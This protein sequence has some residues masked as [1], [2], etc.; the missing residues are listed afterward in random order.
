MC[1][2]V[3]S[4]RS[5]YRGSRIVARSDHCVLAYSTLSMYQWV[6]NNSV[7]TGRY[8]SR[9]FV[10]LLLKHYVTLYLYIAF[11]LNWTYKLSIVLLIQIKTLHRQ[12]PTVTLVLKNIYSISLLWSKLKNATLVCV[13][14]IMNTVARSINILKLKYIMHLCYTLEFI[15]VCIE[16]YYLI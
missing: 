10:K 14:A 7:L 1:K 16:I 4:W 2:H 12:T 11:S 15:S 9:H 3:K 8:L 13:N 5:D 6:H